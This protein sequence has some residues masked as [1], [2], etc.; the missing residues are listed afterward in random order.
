M[1]TDAHRF[2]NYVLISV[3]LWLIYYFVCFV[4]FVVNIF[5]TWMQY[6]AVSARFTCG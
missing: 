1:N 2:I 3:Y 6:D 5:L 4:H